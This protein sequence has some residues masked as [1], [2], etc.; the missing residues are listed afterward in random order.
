MEITTPDRDGIEV[1]IHAVGNQTVR[2]IS[3]ALDLLK[4][5]RVVV[6]VGGPARA[7]YDILGALGHPVE[8]LVKR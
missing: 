7:L 4:P 8:V 6:D 2:D 5:R 3:D 1:T